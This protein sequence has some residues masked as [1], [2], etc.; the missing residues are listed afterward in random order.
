MDRVF[1]PCLASESVYGCII[2]VPAIPPGF[3]VDICCF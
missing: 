3:D 1:G 2:E